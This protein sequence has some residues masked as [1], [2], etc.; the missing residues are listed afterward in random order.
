MEINAEINKIFG[1]EMAKLFAAQIS[2]TELEDAARKCWREIAQDDW[3]YNGSSALHKAVNQVYLKRIEE[4][5]NKILDS[6]GGGQKDTE[7]KAREIIEQIRQKT[8]EKIVESV[9][10]RIAML[11]V[12]YEGVD[13]RSYIERV[14]YETVNPH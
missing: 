10:S 7:T 14:I 2:D 11:S 9:S 4:A 3:Y 13:L 8:Q 6:E 5:V 1:Q 12:G